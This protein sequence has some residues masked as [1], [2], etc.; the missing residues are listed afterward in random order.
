MSTNTS[1]EVL[2]A[3]LRPVTLGWVLKQ[4]AILV[5]ILVVAMGGM[6][7]LTYASIDP[8][9]ES[10]AEAVNERPAPVTNVNLSL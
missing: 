4:T 7:W 3:Q 9:I 1:A 5:L 2:P 6:A 8:V 10:D